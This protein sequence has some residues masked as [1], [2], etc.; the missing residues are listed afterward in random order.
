MWLVTIVGVF[1][2]Y[3]ATAI[4]VAG[5]VHK[6]VQYARTPAP[7]KIPTTPAPIT[8]TGVAGR[9]VREVVLFESL[10]KASKWTWLFGWVFHAA[11][12]VVLVGHLRY[13]TEPVWLPA[14]LVQGNRSVRGAC[15]GGGSRRVVGTP[16]SSSA[17][18]A[19]SP[20]RR[21]T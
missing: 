1:V 17:G 15:D 3:A 9:L 8:R 7:L 20:L 5:V 6:L 2:A 13:F 11:L 14:A 4:L 19:T 12:L 18:C 10:F 21:I 16:A